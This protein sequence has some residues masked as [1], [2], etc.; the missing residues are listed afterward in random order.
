MPE[1]LRFSTPDGEGDA[2]V[3]FPTNRPARVIIFAMDAFGLRPALSDM[4][5]RL[6]SGGWI[7]VQPNLYWRSG[8]FAPF[9]AR[10]TF[11]DRSER[12]RIFSLMNALQ[13]ANVATDVDALLASLADDPRVAPGPI[14]VVGYC[15]GGRQALYL[16]AHLGERAAAVAS[17]HGGGLVRPDPTSPHLGAPRIRARCYFAV[18]DKDSN[19]TS[20]DF[21]VLD[22]TLTAAGVDYRMEFYP[23]ALHGFAAPD[24]TVFDEEASERHWERLFTLFG[25]T[26]GAPA[27][28]P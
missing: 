6:A 27:A 10:T 12:A 16:A 8:P 22:E 3:F 15:M 13:P 2:L 23:D 20:T 9:D 25:E 1:T 19:F 7:V 21:A 28:A 4:A 26:L 18:A 14:G 24:M 5:E 17:I 11:D